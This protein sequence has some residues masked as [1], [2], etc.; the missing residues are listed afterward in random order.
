MAQ[1]SHGQDRKSKRPLKLDEHRSD[2]EDDQPVLEGQISELYKP[3][4]FGELQ[5]EMWQYDGTEGF[6]QQLR[7]ENLRDAGQ[8]HAQQ[9][10]Q[11]KERDREQQR[12][13][14]L[15]NER[16]PPGRYTPKEEQEEE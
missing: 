16:Y 9:M 7:L 13:R 15:S 8:G 2:E 12:D 3:R 11:P 14:A 4:Q 1:D 5:G 10:P 6:E